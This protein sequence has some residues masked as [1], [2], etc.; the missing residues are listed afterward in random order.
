MRNFVFFLLC[1]W[2]IPVTCYGKMISVED[3][4]TKE[5][6][7][8]NNEDISSFTKKHKVNVFFD[9]NNLH[10]NYKNTNDVVVYIEF[11]NGKK[12]AI[13]MNN[14]TYSR[15]LEEVKY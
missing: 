4:T 8:I 15:F 13:N 5:V 9:F 6:F 14:D 7:Y 1:V 2:L 3:S 10:M 12:L 11:I